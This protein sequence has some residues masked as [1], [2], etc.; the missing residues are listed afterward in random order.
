MYTVLYPFMTKQLG[1]R[2]YTK[3]TFAVIFNFW[4]YNGDRPTRASLSLIQ[5]ITGASRPTIVRAIADLIEMNYISAERVPGKHTVYAVIIPAEILSDFIITYQ[6]KLVN[7]VDYCWLNKLTGGSLTV[8]PQ[9][10]RNNKHINNS[11]LRVRQANEYF[12][13]NLIE[14]K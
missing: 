8:K 4:L 5:S 9:K 3:E 2:G 14:A 11:T 6:R 12:T 10:K 1:L 7:Q 13:D